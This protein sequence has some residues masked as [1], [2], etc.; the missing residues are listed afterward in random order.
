MNSNPA[1]SFWHD[2]RKTVEDESRSSRSV[3]SLTKENVTE[4]KTPIRSDRSLA[5]RIISNKLDRHIVHDIL[6]ENLNMRKNLI[7]LQIY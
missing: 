3:T 7:F 6:S 2:T 1:T 4:V 5:L